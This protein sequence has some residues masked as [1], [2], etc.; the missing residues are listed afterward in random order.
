MNLV[1]TA[2]NAVSLI[3]DVH[4]SLALVEDGDTIF[5]NSPELEADER[6]LYIGA[7]LSRTSQ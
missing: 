5:S 4:L 3:S 1:G 2:A 6:T 7:P